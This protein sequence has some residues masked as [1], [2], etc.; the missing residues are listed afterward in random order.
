MQMMASAR[1]WWR[2]RWWMPAFALFLGTC[3]LVAFWVGGDLREGIIGFAVLAGIGLVSLFGSRSETISGL[4]GPGRDERWERIDILATAFS[5]LVLITLLIALW[6]YEIANGRS[7]NP[8]GSLCAV[9]GL[10]YI[11][12]VAWLRFRS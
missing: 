3:V 9:A 10:S 8:S 5:G 1:P 12:G 11:A 6:L 2:R 4:S 7:G